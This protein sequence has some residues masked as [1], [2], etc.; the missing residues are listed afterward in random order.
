MTTI[1]VFASIFD[2]AGH[3]LCIRQNYGERYW[4]TPGG[5]LEAGEAPADGLIR[6]V[7]EEIGAAIA[8]EGLIGAY[9]NPYK[10]DLIL[11]FAARLLTSLQGWRP[12]AEI[13]ALDFFPL[14][15]LPQPMTA[16]TRC[17]LRD[18]AAGRN[19]QYRVFDGPD[20]MRSQLYFA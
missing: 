12:H 2:T 6:E 1:G 15:R 18:A 17:R 19:G 4:T 8:I 20:R 3:A 5:R 7:R 13:D 16:N 11:C 9:A 14:D 10:D